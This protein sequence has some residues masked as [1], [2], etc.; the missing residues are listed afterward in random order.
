[1][2]EASTPPPLPEMHVVL[3]HP[4][5]PPNTGNVARLCFGNAVKLHLIEPLGFILDDTRLKRAGLDFWDKL[6]WEKHVS[7]DAFLAKWPQARE[8]G[9]C[10]TTKGAPSLW[11]SPWPSAPFLIFGCETQG[12]PRAILDLYPQGQVRIPMRRFGEGRSLNL[13]NA[14]AVGVYEALRRIDIEAEE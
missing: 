2:R 1:M 12:L 5:I 10:F 14:V 6:D 4:E 11:K 13:S 7:F 9:V 8:R 3:V